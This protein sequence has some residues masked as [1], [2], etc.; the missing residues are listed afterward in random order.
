MCRLFGLHAG[1][2][3]VEATFW[4]LDAPS[5]LAHQSHA[6]P[7]GFGLATFCADGELDL[8]RGPVR[9]DGDAEFAQAARETRAATFL[10]HVRYADT[11][12]V[13]EANTHPFVLDGRAF[14][15][16]GVVGDHAL[17]RERLGDGLQLV[18]GETDSELAFAFMTKVVREHDGD[19]RAGIVAA[20]RELAQEIELYSINFLLATPEELWALRYPEKNELWILKRPAGGRRGT[21]HLD[22]ASAYGTLRM[23]SLEGANRPFVVIASEPMDEDPGWEPIASGELVHVGRDLTVTREL[24]LDQPPRK[25]MVLKGR[26][27]ESQAQEHR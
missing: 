15:H 8:V 14:A 12:E 7:D 1:D 9:A 5:S 11:G 18:F 23:R 22:E 19:I 13:S 25:P 17:L 3:D 26:A 4:L 24:I 10:A 27:V 16:N 2:S 6:N 21:H 20:A